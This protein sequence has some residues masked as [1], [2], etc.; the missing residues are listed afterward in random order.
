MRLLTRIHLTFPRV[1]ITMS[2]VDA[3]LSSSVRVHDG[4]Q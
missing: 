4:E 1:P 3:R 2:D